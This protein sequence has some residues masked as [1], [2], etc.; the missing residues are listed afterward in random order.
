MLIAGT[1]FALIYLFL[2][3]I[4]I[5]PISLPSR[6]E[7]HPNYLTP[8]GSLVGISSSDTVFFWLEKITANLICQNQQ[9]HHVTLPLCKCPSTSLSPELE[10]FIAK[11]CLSAEQL[12]EGISEIFQ[13]DDFE[14]MFRTSHSIRRG[15]NIFEPVSSFTDIRQIP[16]G[17][18]YIKLPSSVHVGSTIY[19]RIDSFI[20]RLHRRDYNI[21]TVSQLRRIGQCLEIVS[22][23]NNIPRAA[24]EVQMNDW[25]NIV[26]YDNEMVHYLYLEHIG[27][28]DGEDKV[29]GICLEEEGTKVE[30]SP[31]EALQPLL[32]AVNC[33]HEFHER[34]I[35]DWLRKS[36]RNSCPICKAKNIYY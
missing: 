27:R 19:E 18:Y 10:D 9:S 8:Y 23:T 14:V 30:C 26:Q 15:E 36:S 31:G 12:S 28:F 21:P 25:I 13:D 33:G 35:M 7:N 11:R 24:G 6:C 16:F 1:I 4:M 3:A 2:H 17:E 5:Y 34:C 22:T 29:C 20:L 32:I